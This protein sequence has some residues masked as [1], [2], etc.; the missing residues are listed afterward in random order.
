[1][2]MG[3]SLTHVTWAAGIA[4]AYSCLDELTQMF[5]PSRSCDIYDIAADGVGI[6]VGLTSYLIL[7]QLL[8]QV[9]WG[10]RLLHGLSR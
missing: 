2:S 3:K 5:V 10:R 6:A 8:L 4:L 1:P 7:R 9:A